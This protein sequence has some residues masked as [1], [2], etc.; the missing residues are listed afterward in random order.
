MY[1]NTR[2]VILL[3]LITVLY[4]LP[5]LIAY[6]RNH[7]RRQ[8]I[9]VVNLLLGWIVFVVWPIVFIWALLGESDANEPA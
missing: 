9:A 1:D 6:A 5:T 8:F 3:I 2:L 4:M 7:H